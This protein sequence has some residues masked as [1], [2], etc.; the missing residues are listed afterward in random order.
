MA[1]ALLMGMAM[2]NTC[3]CGAKRDTSASPISARNMATSTGAASSTAMRTR[4]SSC[5]SITGVESGCSTGSQSV[6]LHSAKL[7]YRVPS[8]SENPPVSRKNTM[9]AWLNIN[10]RGEE[11]LPVSGLRVEAMLAPRW[12]ST[13]KPTASKIQNG[14]AAR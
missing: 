3:S 2:K 8:S 1:S 13:K 9:N 7:S 10:P 12:L 14:I 5:A 11:S 6:M 4:R